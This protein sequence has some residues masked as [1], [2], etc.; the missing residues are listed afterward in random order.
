MS[1][2]ASSF[3]PHAA[4]EH[5]TPAPSRVLQR[6]CSCGEHALDGGECESC[7]KESAPTVQRAANGGARVGD[8]PA[9]VHDVLRSSGQ[10]LDS[11]TRAFF[12]PRFAHDFSQVRV[13][14]DA[15][16]AQ[17]AVAVNALAY[18]AGRHVVFGAGQLAPQ[19]AIGRRLLAHELTH[20]VQQ[21]SNERS[22]VSAITAPHDATELE[23]EGNANAIE[24]G[25]RAQQTTQV[26][27]RPV[28]ARRGTVPVARPP[29]ARPVPR[30]GLRPAPG[31]AGG[32]VPG[33]ER[34]QR[35]MPA[36]TDE[37]F[38]EM[39]ERAKK[40]PDYDAARDELER[41]V[42]TLT[43]G[44]AAPAFVSVTP[45]T[46]SVAIAGGPALGAGNINVTYQPRRFHLLDAIEH[47]VQ[48]VNSSAELLDVFR[49]YFPESVLKLGGTI[50][51]SARS[52]ATVSLQRDIEFKPQSLD[53]AGVA[54]T[55]VFLP[56]ATKRSRDN[57][58]VSTDFLAKTLIKE[59]EQHEENMNEQRRK[60]ML[61]DDQGRP[62]TTKEVDRKAGTPDQI[63]H[64]AYAKKVTG[65][66]KDFQITAPDGKTQCTTDGRD[67]EFVSPK[68]VWEVK[69]RHEWA[70]SYGIPGAIF[71]PYFTGRPP[72]PGANPAGETD[73][74]GRVYKIE[75]QRLRCLDVT[76]RCG[77]K[78]LVR[79]RN[80]GGGRLHETTLVKR[81]ARV[82][83]IGQMSETN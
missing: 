22:A 20:V 39:Y 48:A 47:D 68:S 83:Q 63:A 37:S 18:T 53:P 25:L 82:P 71:A 31:S 27:G 77:F 23:A 69:T 61:A 10:P 35:P 26:T 44:G 36:E 38:D 13:H 16:A 30:P 19:T 15:K 75:E 45:K 60:R 56:A 58:N 29:L 73:D 50:A 8:V 40:A 62:C 24:Q 54:R 11:A 64:N 70:T 66:D 34:D 79:F 2:Y 12:E 49:A 78:Y 81:P 6:T 28:L 57:P 55:A 43:R 42:A 51:G 76:Q 32:A 21:R 65:A 3:K 14:T 4:K 1:T 72:T 17:S 41:P 46:Q 80:Q 52:G 59:L 33:S 7:R 67:P 9:L 5:L 74:P